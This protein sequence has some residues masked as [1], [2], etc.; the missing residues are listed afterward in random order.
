MVVINK[1]VLWPILLYTIYVTTITL[2]IILGI[3]A[4]GIGCG[5][6]NIPGVY[7]NV[8]AY[9]CWIKQQIEKV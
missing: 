3:V 7:V 4:W 9:V 8:A 6:E 1:R 2:I 5:N